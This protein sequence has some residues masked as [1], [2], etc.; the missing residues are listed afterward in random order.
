[1][2]NAI[3]LLLLVLV[4][5]QPAKSLAQDTPLDSKYWQFSPRL[6]Y[7]MPEYKNNT[8]YIDYASGLEFGVSVDYYFDWFGL[9]VDVDY[10]NNSPENTYPSSNLYEPDANTAINS[11]NI[12]E[13]KITRLFYGVGPN[14][15]FR[16]TSGRFK[17]ELN[18]RFGLASIKGGKT[19]LTGTSSSGTVFPLNYHAGY[20][21]SGVLTFK[22]QLRFTYFLNDNFGIQLGSYYM[23]H[24][25]VKE[26]S[27]S[28][29]AAS[30]QT[31]SNSAVGS[32]EPGVVLSD[33]NAMIRAEACDCDISSIGVF[34]GLTYKVTTSGEKK[35]ETCKVCGDR[36]FPQCCATCGCN[37]TI[38]AV[39]K[40]TGDV[41]PETDVVLTDLNGY[42]VHSGVTNSFGVVVFNDV[43]TSHYLI[44][45]KL[46]AIDLVEGIITEEDFKACQKGVR[47]IQKDIM[48]EDENFILRGNVRECT[49]NVG[50]EGVEVTLNNTRDANQKTTLSNSEG[51]FSFHLNQASVYKLKGK[52]DGYY[53]NE[54]EVS[55][56]SLDRD[57]T[58]FMD[59]EMCVDPCG[60]AIKLEN[61][62]FDLNKATISKAAKR[63]LQRVVKLMEN[64]PNIQVEMTSHTDSQGADEYNRQLS[65]RRAN[66][67]VNYIVSQ[68]ISKS[69]LSAR[70]AGETELKN[71]KCQNTIPC[72]DEE[73]R[74]NR[75][76][77][78]KVICN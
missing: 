74:I 66:A 44:R 24:F 16:S 32:G 48:Y 52:K 33:D 60:K 41:L 58:L 30:Y 75:R 14:A 56:E 35:I 76:T 47:G 65:Q 2:K 67:T 27:D 9:G 55:T 54:V 59:F 39:D 64:N 63:D 29:G 21:D 37:V 22:G 38:T 61:I 51:D 73:H 11:F 77:E 1:M 36:H 25:G 10:I 49:T 45:G 15:Q 28:K 40:F 53:S 69:R 31:F 17:T 43:A 68:G 70:G 13:E 62:N 78:F 26:L 4:L 72:T 50:V 8:P 46:Y 12:N 57:V 71:T 23:K 7:D 19:E 6:G 42:V 3:K 34:A 18:T 20:K 5:V